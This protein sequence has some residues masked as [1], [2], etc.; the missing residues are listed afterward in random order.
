MRLASFGKD[1][2]GSRAY[3]HPLLHAVS[4]MK[5]IKVVVTAT[6]E[7]PDSWQIL[8]HADGHPAGTMMLICRYHA[9]N[10]PTNDSHRHACVQSSP[11][12]NDAVSQ[13]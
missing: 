2:A 10:P 12:A 6:V 8:E 5:K 11:T 7:L 1:V 9:L 4:R 3:E 13:M